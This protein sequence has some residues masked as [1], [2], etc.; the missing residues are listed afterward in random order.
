M[1]GEQITI[2][3]LRETLGGDIGAFETERIGDGHIGVNMRV[4]LTGHDAGLPD[5]VVLKLPATDE[6]SLSAAKMLRHYEREVRFYQEVAS[7]VDMRTP[8]CLYADWTAETNDFILV[9]EDMAP[10]VQGDQLA[11]CSVDQAHDAVRELARLHGPRWDDPTLFDID[12]MDHPTGD[13]DAGA[14][15]AMMW[16][17]FFP[18]Y[19]DAH[20]AHLADDEVE[21]ATRFGERL[22]EWSATRSGP[23]AVTHGDYRLDNM[24]FAVSP[25]RP[26]VTVVDWQS[27]G[28]GTPVTDLSYFCSAG[29][30]PAER[31]EHERSLVDTYAQTLADG[32]GID[33]DDEWLWQQYRKDPF[34][35]LVVAVVASQ[36]VTLNDRSEAMFGV[37]G[38]RA[39]RMA[40]D[41]D[42]LDAF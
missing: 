20:R 37:M 30:L 27:P 33:L 6:R 29:L 18:A 23:L 22:Q 19:L 8:R 16:Q 42:S 28:H 11:G 32:Y 40:I 38:S 12:W 34:S 2:D 4:R 1:Q 5:S 17:M 21:V 13:G 14:G 31:L 9:M 35:G 41:L 36:I 26:P 39:M 3:W 7:T 10:A 24:L 25:D 15:L